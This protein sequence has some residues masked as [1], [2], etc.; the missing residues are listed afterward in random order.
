MHR[1][2][3]I[4]QAVGGKCT[5]ET[6][7]PLME[8]VLSLF[9]EYEKVAFNTCCPFLNRAVDLLWADNDFSTL[10]AYSFSDIQDRKS[11]FQ[12]FQKQ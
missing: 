10:T 11:H 6:I 2:L 7:V 12:Q 9:A 5:A 1:A 3:Q 8:C 4:P